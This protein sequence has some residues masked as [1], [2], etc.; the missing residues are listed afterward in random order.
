LK[1]GFIRVSNATHGFGCE[2]GSG[3]AKARHRSGFHF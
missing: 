3:G 2:Y 1:K